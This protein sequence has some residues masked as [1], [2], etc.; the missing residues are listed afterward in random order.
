MNPNDQ[1][2]QSHVPITFI[3]SLGMQYE[4]FVNTEKSQCSPQEQQYITHLHLE[5]HVM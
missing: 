3:L 1:A 2:K 4:I 5:L